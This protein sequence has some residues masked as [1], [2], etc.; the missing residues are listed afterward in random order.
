MKTKKT[1]IIV[2][3]VLQ[4]LFLVLASCNE[5]DNDKS[6]FIS[7]NQSDNTPNED[8]SENSINGNSDDYDQNITSLIDETGSPDEVSNNTS[9]GASKDASSGTSSDK[10]QTSS[11]TSSDYF[12]DT[13]SETSN[14][15]SSETLSDTSS[16][17]SSEASSDTSSNNSSEAS[18]D[19]S[20]KPDIVEYLTVIDCNLVDNNC[21]VIVGK[22]EVGAIVTATANNQTTKSS[23]DNGF[24]SLR[25]KKESG[26]TKVTIKAEGMKTEKIEYSAVPKTIMYDPSF[27]VVG[28]NHYNFFFKKMIDDYTHND[29]LSEND[30]LSMRK[31]LKNRIS[32]LKLTCPNTEIVYM[33]VPSKASIYPELVPQDYKKG[34]GRSRL[35]QLHDIF[36]ESG[37]EYIDLLDVFEKH[38][39]DEKKLYWNTDSHWSDYGA[40]IAY[41]ELFD[42]I[43]RRFPAAA[44]YKQEDFNFIG[45]F[46]QGGDMIYYMEMDQNEA[47]EYNYL[48]EPKFD[49]HP[50]IKYISRYK[51]KDYLSY[52]DEMVPERMIQTYSPELPDLYVFRDSFST[53]IYDILADRGNNTLYKAMWYNVYN[54]NEIKYYSPDY[55]I[56]IA[57]EW[58]LR[59]II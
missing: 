10:S 59:S 46:Y 55:I 39:D 7:E 37:V 35:E 41:R 5:K 28:G 17:N 36:R 52:T 8:G 50:G 14:N 58:N 9:S 6:D 11:G 3:V 42:Y 25:F 13:S 38:K 29:I 53:Q 21:F 34:L 19:T 57:S 32:G 40:F 33:I 24:Y 18:S 27:E 16:D 12:K 1:V 49:I 51:S 15:T 45:D 44:P 4:V 20:S 22:C 48:R 30:I 56:Y 23:S 47:R 26:I 54:I 2:L 43:S 31:K